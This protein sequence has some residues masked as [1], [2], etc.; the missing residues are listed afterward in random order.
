[1]LRLPFP[2]SFEIHPLRVCARV[3][4][5]RLTAIMYTWRGCS[6]TLRLRF[7]ELLEQF[8]GREYHLG[9]LRGGGLCNFPHTVATLTSVLNRFVCVFGV[10]QAET[11]RSSRCWWDIPL[12]TVQMYQ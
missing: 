12:S 8:V 11:T 6:G 9:T 2:L 4:R 10:V 1:M 7:L 3:G 5:L